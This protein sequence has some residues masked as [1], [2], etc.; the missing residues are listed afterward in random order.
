MENGY[1]IRSRVDTEDGY[2]ITKD[3]GPS[4]GVTTIRVHYVPTEPQK[5]AMNQQ[6]LNDFLG[7]LGYSLKEVAAWS[8]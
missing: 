7:T 1:P 4:G 3:Y 2:I 5:A 8:L 6:L